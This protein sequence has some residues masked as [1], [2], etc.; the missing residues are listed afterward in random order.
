[1]ALAPMHPKMEG[2]SLGCTCEEYKNEARRIQSSLLPLR[3]LTLRSV[4]IASRYAPFAE[5]GGDFADFFILPDGMIGLYL[6]DVVGKGLPAAMYAALVMGTIRGI[7]KCGQDPA[8]V[9]ALL[10]D[11][12][13]VR[14]VS[15]RFCTTLYA[16]FDPASRQ[17]AFSNAGLPFPIMLSKT[18]CRPLGQGGLPSGMFPKSTYDLYTVQLVEGDVVLFATDGLHELCNSQGIEFST[19]R[20]TE[21]WSQC[22]GTSA[23]H[24]LQF[25][26][27]ALKG[28]SGTGPQDDVTAVALKVAA[29]P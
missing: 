22:R 2:L 23:T 10:N 21:I 1:M 4:E 26:F 3:S 28:F 12:L 15:G 20:L 16:C 6:G 19:S 13:L 27:D 5:V 11:R 24:A 25:L 9:L 8:A 18:G 17:L 7:H 14:P 29:N